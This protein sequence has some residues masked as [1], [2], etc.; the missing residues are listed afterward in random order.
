M[1]AQ[2]SGRRSESFRLLETLFERATRPWIWPVDLPVRASPW[3]LHSRV[4]DVEVADDSKLAA[5]PTDTRRD[6]G[7]VPLFA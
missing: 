4:V 1:Y 7:G 3:G 2:C 5:L 6:R